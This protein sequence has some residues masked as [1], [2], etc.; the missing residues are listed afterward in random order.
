MSGGERGGLGA[1]E[2]GLAVSASS[3]QL[4]SFCPA[5][6]M[7]VVVGSED[8]AP[9]SRVWACPRLTVLPPA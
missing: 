4:G 9:G 6:N 3:V 7:G 1:L 2:E 8:K 5:G